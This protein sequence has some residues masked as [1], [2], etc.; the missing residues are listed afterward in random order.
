MKQNLLINKEQAE[1]KIKQLNIYV[2]IYI[3]IYI[4]IY[5]H[6]YIYTHTYILNMLQRVLSKLK[7]ILTITTDKSENIE[8]AIEVHTI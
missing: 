7:D 5:I 8:D 2:C 3:C 1:I 4:Y 6:I